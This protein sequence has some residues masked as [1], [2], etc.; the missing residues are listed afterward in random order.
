MH[1]FTDSSNL[2]LNHSSVLSLLDE[3]LSTT[4][5]CFSGEA[6]TVLRKRGISTLTMLEQNMHWLSGWL[7]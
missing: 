1:T 6:Y 2:S 4:V 3:V 7:I 5:F